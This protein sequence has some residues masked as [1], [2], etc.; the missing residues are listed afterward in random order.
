M[1][2]SDQ[3]KQILAA[4]ELH[5]DASLDELQERS[6]VGKNSIRYALQKLQFRGIIQR[7]PFVN[8]Y[9]LGFTDFVVF[10]SLTSPGPARDI[11]QAFRKLMAHPC[12]T[13]VGELGGPYQY[14]VAIFS[15]SVSEFVVFLEFLRALFEGATIKKIVRITKRFTRYNRAYLGRGVTKEHLDFGVMDRQMK[16]DA[17]DETILLTMTNHPALTSRQQAKRIR[18]PDSTWHHRLR[19]LKADGIYLGELFSLD[20]GAL[21]YTFYNLH[22]YTNGLYG[23]LE[24]KIRAW[25]NRH[26]HVVHLIECI[27]SWDF[28]IG[29]EVEQPQQI[30]QIVGELYEQF[31]GDL[32]QIEM[33]PIFANRKYIF[34]RPFVFTT[35]EA[36]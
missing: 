15:Q 31:G 8:M 36:K 29:V 27:A 30:T 33:V 1:K 24:K 18:L 3:E 21:G 19:R 35:E 23:D 34:F 17:L 26:P 22:V 16:C 9:P 32:V 28:E 25:A 11:S 13:W 6:G 20:T 7:V 10:F 5:A 12:V 2:L 14:G 4:C